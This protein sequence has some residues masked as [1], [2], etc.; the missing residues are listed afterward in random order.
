MK[1]AN[2]LVSTDGDVRL[3]DFGIARDEDA[4]DQTTSEERVLGTLSYMAPEQ[5][6]G[7][8]ATGA[9]DVWAAALTLYSRLTGENPFRARS[10]GELLERLSDGA[11][12]LHEL[13]PDLP[14]ALS[15]VLARAL[16]HDPGPA[17][18][19]IAFR[20]QLL[21]LHPAGRGGR[22]L[23]RAGVRPPGPRRAAAGCP[24]RRSSSTA[25]CR[26]PGR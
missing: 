26:P 10:L 25:R 3:T 23:Q 22:A 8:R 21:A 14:R 7:E 12:P 6:K 5:A 4:R 9:T 11:Q 18:S 20:D 24:S 17:A 15:R 1:P 16:D 19:A 13:R 2:I